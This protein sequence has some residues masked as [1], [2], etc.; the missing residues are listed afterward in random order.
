M[1][2]A[3]A[4]FVLWFIVFMLSGW[5]KNFDKWPPVGAFRKFIGDILGIGSFILFVLGVVEI[6][7]SCS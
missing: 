5:V 3:I 4:Y 1:G 2:K 7:K 6:F